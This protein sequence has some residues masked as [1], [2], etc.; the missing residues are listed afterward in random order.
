MDRWQPWD[1]PSAA[2]R[3]MADYVLRVSSRLGARECFALL[4]DWD[5]HEAVIPLTRLVHDGTPRVGQRFV[6]RT[7][8]GPFGFDDSMVVTALEAPSGDG[9][10]EGPGLCEVAKVGRVVGGRVRWTVVATANETEVEWAQ[11]LTIPWLPAF[12]DGLV[13]AVGRH[14]YGLALRRILASSEVARTGPA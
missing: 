2:D 11:T 1:V 7:G 8:V 3:G 13:G 10:G 12:L 9:P 5:A 4:S 6:A 14:A